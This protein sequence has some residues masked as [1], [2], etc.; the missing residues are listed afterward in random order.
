MR[1]PMGV[2]VRVARRVIVVLVAGMSDHIGAAC[3]TLFQGVFA[4]SR[5]RWHCSLSPGA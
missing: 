4:T 1:I 2:A 5:R 3:R